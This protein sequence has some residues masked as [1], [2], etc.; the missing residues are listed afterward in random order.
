[1]QFYSL[2]GPC[3]CTNIEPKFCGITARCK[4]SVCRNTEHRNILE[5]QGFLGIV[6]S[7][8]SYCL[9]PKPENCN[10]TT[11]TSMERYKN[12]DGRISPEAFL[13]EARKESRGKLKIFLGASPG[14]GKTYAMLGDAAS[15][16]REGADII[17]G[18]VETH[19]RKETEAQ[20]KD[21]EIIPRK[22][23]IYRD[24][25]FEEM[26]IDAILERRPD[27]VLVD[28]L[29]HTNIEGSRHPKR[30]QDVEEILGAGIDVYSTINIQH[31]E[32]LNDLVSRISGVQVKETV[33]DRILQMA[34]EIELVDIPPKE[35]QKRLQEG[36]VYVPEQAQQ[37][38]KH[39][40]TQ[41]NLTAL[42]EMALRFTA[43]RVD[44]QMLQI[45][46]AQGIRE[47][48]PTRERV[49]VC[50]GDDYDG[51][52]LVRACHQTATQWKAPWIAL[53]V[54]TDKEATIASETDYT[55]MALQLAEELGGEVVTLAAGDI[56]GEILEFAKSRNVSHVIVGKPPRRKWF[57]FKDP[58]AIELYKRSNTI[59]VI[60]VP[61]GDI[62]L[63]ERA[64]EKI[65]HKKTETNLFKDYLLATLV[66]ALIGGVAY[67]ISG[68]M[69]LSNLY[70]IFLLGVLYISLYRGL[71]PSI[72]TIALSVAIDNYFFGESKFTFNTVTQEQLLNISFFLLIAFVIS[73][74]S[75]R[76]RKQVQT[77]QQNAMRT[78]SL[79]EFSKRISAA[80]DSDTVFRAIIQHVMEILDVKATLLLPEDDA[81]KVVSGYPNLDEVS[82]GAAT[83]AWKRNE[84]TGY[85]TSTLPASGWFFIPMK[86]DSGVIGVLGIE[87]PDKTKTLLPNQKRVLDAISHQAAVAI[88]RTQ[89]SETISEAKVY[90]ET[91]KLRSALLSSI[92]H[93]FYMP[94]TI[95]MHKVHDMLS[96]ESGTKDL[97]V[98]D[99]LN[100]IYKEVNRME[101]F[102]KNL[103]EM[104]K[105][106]KAKLEIK[107]DWVAL[108]GVVEVAV[109]RCISI[110]GGRQFVSDIKNDLPMLFVDGVLV[111]QVL[112]N[113]IGNACEL[114]I[115]NST[116]NFSA[117]SKK[118]DVVIEVSFEAVDSKREGIGNMFENLDNPLL[119][120][121]K[122]NDVASLRF[123]ICQGIVDAHGGKITFNRNNTLVVILITLPFHPMD[124]KFSEPDFDDEIAKIE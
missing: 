109:E 102:V 43:E 77:V 69:V 28:E 82:K 121:T 116:I 13:E 101:R 124:I 119:Q 106:G 105:G 68:I 67:G 56:V 41:S 100:I 112:F 22:K 118:E 91:E 40:F 58:F 65:L 34:D 45:M 80:R 10:P 49:M 60:L 59:K 8:R 115:P 24:R 72:Y 71:L 74:Q 32:S 30:F 78:A 110:I 55:T 113:V 86:T 7:K 104:T 37:A 122:Q 23:I 61:T 50:I 94:I 89:L 98:K 63:R 46:Q 57:K 1:L 73:R 2:G 19:G 52:E 31:I 64:E 85:S 51:M 48:W 76:V 70:L 95:V 114:S 88:E 54:N 25:E 26:D 84:A 108:R 27:V 33:P 103:I 81:L 15:L 66:S 117:S 79:Y 97:A 42:R 75:S 99:N 83:W 39:F 16:K 21:L 17:I 93:D 36:K 38:I 123:T 120:S 14:V 6:D 107:R 53:H 4:Q 12:D 96:T 92:S 47:S 87:F 3:F 18:V 20:T 90:S 111:E 5:F 9:S 29:A 62:V 44:S 11:E 35:L